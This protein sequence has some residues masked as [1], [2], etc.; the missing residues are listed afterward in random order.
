MYADFHGQLPDRVEPTGLTL[1]MTSAPEEWTHEGGVATTVVDLCTN[2]EVL[3]TYRLLHGRVTLETTDPAWRPM[4]L[5][6]ATLYVGRP[7][8]GSAGGAL[9][10]SLAVYSW[11]HQPVLKTNALGGTWL[12][13]QLDPVPGA[14]VKV[15]PVQGVA[16]AGGWVTTDDSGRAVVPLWAETSSPVDAAGY[17]QAAVRLKAVKDRATVQREV[18]P[19]I[20]Y[21]LVEALNGGFLVG[22]AGS[23]LEPSALF[24]GQNLFPGDVVQVGSE[25]M[26]SGVYLTL[27]F[28]NDPRVTLQSDTFGGV[29]AVVGQGSLDHR[30]PLLQAAVKN[31]A[32]DFRGDPR[33]YA[34]MLVYKALGNVVDGF[35]GIPDPVGWTVTTP[36]GALEDWLADFGESAY[37]P[38]AQHRLAGGPGPTAGDP[39]AADAP[40]VA[41]VLDFYR[42]GTARVYNRGATVRLQ[43]PSAA[44][45]SPAAHL[46][47]CV[48]LARL[49]EG[50][51]PKAG[52]R[53]ARSRRHA[54][55][56]HPT[57]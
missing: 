37:Q 5:F 29:R 18:T 36:G 40:W 1:E 35:L 11:A 46:N 56:E 43:G 27:R 55:G 20:P 15:E 22:R 57:G 23:L 45:R 12:D 25:A 14:E 24:P 7:L 33:R 49:G 26:G 53:P 42:D 52:R 4:A 6:S 10:G 16:G 38:R 39:M 51:P 41:G 28:C 21:A 31:L 50:S 47:A 2:R 3:A 48:E 9:G 44:A 19:R 8:S 34:R 54:E 17:I 13:Y 30:T 32:Q